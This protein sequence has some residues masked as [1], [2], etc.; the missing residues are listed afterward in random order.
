M[1]KLITNILLLCLVF[2]LFAQHEKRDTVYQIKEVEVTDIKP[3]LKD[4]SLSPVQQITKQE[5]ERMSGL[6]VAEAINH[7]SGVTLKDY[8]G[9][10]GL[11]TVMV[12]SL[13]ANHTSVFIDGIQFSDAATG[14]VDLGKISLTNKEEI[15]MYIGQS[16]DLSQPARYYA[17]ASVI[18]IKSLK[19]DFS[20]K[21][22][23]LNYG[24][25]SGSFGLLQNNILTQG[26]IGDKL[27]AGFSAN[28]LTANGEYPFLLKYGQNLDSVLTRKNSDIK[29]LLTDADVEYR[30]NGQ[31]TISYKFYFYNSERGLPGA[32]VFY[33]PFSRQ[34]LWNKDFYNA[35]KY[36]LQV[37]E[38][39]S[40]FTNLKF[41]RNKLR[42]L[43]PEYLNEDG[44][45]D[46]IYLQQEFY[47]SQVLRYQFTDSLTM[48]LAS[49]FFVNTMD[50][51][52]YN[53]AGPVRFNSLTSL[54]A[55]YRLNRIDFDANILS[56]IVKEKTLRGEAAPDRFKLSPSFAAG[57]KI[58]KDGKI[59]IKF[60]YKDIF[61]MP[62][63]NDLY[64][65]LVGNNN[66]RPENARQYNL[67]LSAYTGFWNFKFL[68]FNANVFY[69]K[70]TDKIVA[71][72]TKNLFVWSMQNIGVVD[73][74]GFDLQ[75][76]IESLKFFNLFKIVSSANYT[77]QK[78]LDITNPTS[79]TYKNQIP[80]VPFE[81]FSLRNSIEVRNFALSYNVLFNG[82][83]YA[84]GENIYQ[85][86][87]PGWWE[88]DL[89]VNYEKTFEN[90]LVACFK[91]EVNNLYDVQYEVIRSFPMPG[92]SY[93]VSLLLKY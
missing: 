28:I 36:K 5:I 69:N 10:G 39:I 65:T 57:Y 22:Y 47:G 11:K 24:L 72:P 49:D 45:L 26:K 91:F 53:Y 74:R 78:A 4:K 1:K 46:N 27:F 67:G 41:S 66:L 68:S 9:V 63:F 8:G 7:F 75:T 79:P 56:T 86:M 61:R 85:N 43:D 23:N 2:T 42:Y 70:V 40:L 84:L 6:S 48:A 12:R 73:V 18:E 51:N 82:F 62:S 59:R 93:F 30:I 14:Q 17:A 89:S 80:Y 81:S 92:R 76:D 35:I 37:N 77:F 88:T 38:K 3:R 32:V 13:G 55:N 34:R 20:E 87:I 64:Y 21:N 15:S 29:S 83:R 25:K 90:K 54:A 19:K 44:R 71:I 31:Q 16:N 52:L 58:L 50:A 33:N 60:F